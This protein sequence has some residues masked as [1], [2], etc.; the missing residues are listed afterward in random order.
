[1][2]SNLDQLPSDLLN[3]LDAALPLFTEVA[4]RAEFL[5]GLYLFCGGL[6]ICVTF[7]SL[8]WYLRK[9]IFICLTAALLGFGVMIISIPS[10]VAPDMVLAREILAGM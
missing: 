9:E 3:R 7:L 6:F 2:P 1:M 10:V 4:I 5:H 8:G